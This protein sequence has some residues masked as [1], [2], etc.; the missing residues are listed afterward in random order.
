MTDHEREL[1]ERDGKVVVL[2]IIGITVVIGKDI[3]VHG[4]GGRTRSERSH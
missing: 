3:T 4:L 1:N 2:G